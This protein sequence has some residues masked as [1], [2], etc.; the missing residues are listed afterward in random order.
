MSLKSL[1]KSQRSETLSQCPIVFPKA[2]SGPKVVEKGQS[3]ASI[4]RQK[5]YS[6]RLKVKSLDIS[7]GSK[8]FTAGDQRK[9]HHTIATEIFSDHRAKL[10]ES[11]TRLTHCGVFQKPAKFNEYA[12]TLN[13]LQSELDRSSQNKREAAE[14]KREQAEMLAVLTEENRKQYRLSMGIDEDGNRIDK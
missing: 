9:S 8:L 3:V 4:Q 5:Y 7:K 10:K 6:A 11:L 1:I 2:K 13:G 14:K 12:V